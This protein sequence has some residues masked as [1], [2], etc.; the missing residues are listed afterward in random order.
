MIAVMYGGLLGYLL[1]PTVPPWMADIAFHV[2]PSLARP[3]ME[4]YNAVVPNVVTQFD[5]NPIAAMPS[6]HCAIPTFMSLVAGRLFGFSGWPVFV[7]TGL[8]YFSVVY[9]GEHYVVDVIA[10]IAL[11]AGAFAWVKRDL[12]ALEGPELDTSEIDETDHVQPDTEHAQDL[13]A[14]ATAVFGLLLATSA[15]V[16][17]ASA[18]MRTEWIPNDAFVERELQGQPQLARFVRAQNAFARGDFDAALAG[19]AGMP[20]SNTFDRRA[21]LSV[22]LLLALDRPAEATDILNLAKPARAQAS[23]HL[24]WRAISAGRAGDLSG[25]E[26]DRILRQLEQDKTHGGGAW[27]ARLE[28]T[29]RNGFRP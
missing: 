22:Q 13:R 24:Y 10:G 11:A 3:I 16:A 26:L 9:G 15:L 25:G 21:R 18:M 4:T 28:A 2:I 1:M 19:L 17:T 27:A 6:L 12:R 14:R 5:T 8:V 7:Y 29:R 20:A 23:E